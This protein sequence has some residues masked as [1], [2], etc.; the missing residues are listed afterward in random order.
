MSS[1]GS[2]PQSA[3]Y[4]GN[5]RSETDQSA[6]P[7]QRA[8]ARGGARRPALTPFPSFETISYFRKTC[9]SISSDISQVISE[10]P[11]L[12]ACAAQ[13]AGVPRRAAAGGTAAQLFP[14]S[15]AQ[16]ASAYPSM[17]AAER[18]SVAPP[19]VHFLFVTASPRCQRHAF[20]CLDQFSTL[21]TSEFFY[22]LDF[23]PEAFPSDQV[24]CSRSAPIPRQLRQSTRIRPMGSEADSRASRAPRDTTTRTGSPPA[25]GNPP[26]SGL[27]PPPAVHSEGGKV[28]V[29]PPPG[30]TGADAR[31]GPTC[32]AG[33]PAHADDFG[34]VRSCSNSEKAHCARG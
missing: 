13:S 23:F 28:H 11:T 6:T 33:I 12:L 17:W 22:L 7:G 21:S 24:E 29:A 15:E 3:S 25:V 18:L 5:E 4:Q 31:A 19:S 27:S 16:A 30:R 32:G 20:K 26:S 34:Q 14:R 10:R 1:T 8:A 9:L 2:S